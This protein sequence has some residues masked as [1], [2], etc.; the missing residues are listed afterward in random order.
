MC[1]FGFLLSQKPSPQHAY[2]LA[3]PS[4]GECRR[5]RRCSF[6]THVVDVVVVAVVVV[7]AAAAVAVVLEVVFCFCHPH[8]TA[9]TAPRG[10][11]RH[12]GAQVKQQRVKP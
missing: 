11:T 10:L 2:K 6:V 8:G 3:L 9:T 5:R 4:N 12:N 1:A 7:V